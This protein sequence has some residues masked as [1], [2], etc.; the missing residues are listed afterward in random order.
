[1]RP[2]TSSGNGTRN[3]HER[4]FRRSEDRGTN[5]RTNTRDHIAHRPSTNSGRGT[6]DLPEAAL[7][8]AWETPTHTQ[9][10]AH[11]QNDTHSTSPPRTLRQAQG[12]ALATPR[13]A[14][15]RRA[16]VAAAGW[17]RGPGATRISQSTRLVRGNRSLS[18][19]KGAPSPSADPAFRPP[20]MR[21]RGAEASTL[22]QPLAERVEA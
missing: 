5:H 1:M 13:V 22:N 10:H 4:A 19:S 18:L 20:W 12:T 16:P 9:H 17:R 2:S 14:E 21:P 6:R 15:G 7:R 8:Q 11:P 3:H